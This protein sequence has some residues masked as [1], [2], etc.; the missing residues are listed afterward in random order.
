MMGPCSEFGIVD[1]KLGA[2]ER[3]SMP[4]HIV[5]TFFF[6][7]DASQ[8]SSLLSL[9]AKNH[10]GK[11]FAKYAVITPE[12]ANIPSDVLEAIPYVGLHNSATGAEPKDS[13]GH[14]IEW[15]QSNI[16]NPAIKVAK[17]IYNGL[18]AVGDLIAHAAEIVAK[19]YMTLYDLATHPDKVIKAVT[20]AVRKTVDALKDALINMA[21]EMFE[22]IIKPVIDALHAY[23]INIGGKLKLIYDDYKAGH[24]PSNEHI[25]ELINAILPPEV[26]NFITA[27]SI[28]YTVINIIVTFGVPGVGTIVSLAIGAAIGIAITQYASPSLKFLNGLWDGTQEALRNGLNS[29]FNVLRTLGLSGID[30]AAEI[31]NTIAFGAGVVLGVMKSCIE[32]LIKDMKSLAG[33]VFGI[34]SIFAGVDQKDTWVGV[35]GVL[36]GFVSLILGA[37]SIVDA[38]ETTL[39]AALFAIN[40]IAG[41]NGLML[42]AVGLVA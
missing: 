37:W 42:S 36:M 12:N 5:G 38:V 6:E 39:D 23:L 30:I 4:V 24:T 7:T 40:L 18:V 35:A 16:V 21:K 19:F 27:M 13:L 20:E 22:K 14:I 41:M 15:L 34:L 33:V 32:G 10:T 1:A 2:I 28:I 3:A 17:F 11:V 8:L 25:K 26:M 29:L 31:V 9:L